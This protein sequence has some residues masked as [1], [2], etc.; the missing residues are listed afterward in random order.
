[1]IDS[2]SISDRKCCK[3]KNLSG[4]VEGVAVGM[5]EGKFTAQLQAYCRAWR[6]YPTRYVIGNAITH[7]ADV[8]DRQ[9]LFATLSDA[10]FRRLK[11]ELFGTNALRADL[12]Q[13]IAFFTMKYPDLLRLIQ[14]LFLEQRADLDESGPLRIHE[15]YCQEFSDFLQ[16]DLPATDRHDIG[17][18]CVEANISPVFACTRGD[19]TAHK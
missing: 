5:R 19:H 4:L 11:R 1:M 10:Q 15:H 13:G 18:H 6:Q 7:L 2:N 12:Q 8:L 14:V 17:I 9:A 16:L 3:E